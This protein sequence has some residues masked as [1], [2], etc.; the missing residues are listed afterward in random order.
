MTFVVRRL[1]FG[2]L[3]LLVLSFGSFCFFASQPESFPSGKPVL[4]E[5]WTW[6]E[7]MGTG[8]SL[9]ALTGPAPPLLNRPATT[10]L[11]ALGH[12]LAMLAV[13]FAIVVLLSVAIGL[14][15]A[16]TRGSALDLLLRALTYLAWATPAFLLALLV[17]KLVNAVGSPHGIGPFPIAGWPGW[18]P[19][20]VGL[21]AGIVSPCPVAGTGLHYASNVLRYVT[22]PALVLA[23]GFVGLHARYLR[24]SLLDA[25]DAPFITTARAKG[26]P[27]RGVI[28]RHAMRASLVTFVGALFADFG[29]VFGAALAVDWVFQLNGFG[30]VLIAEFPIDA[31]AG[32]D[33]YGVQIL[34]LL[35]GA[36][37]VVSS[38]V[39][40][41][42]VH[43][44]DPRTRADR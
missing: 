35:T 1:V 34:L 12:T 20:G 9:H 21:N 16:I 37:V 22:L 11:N 29:A 43:L 41:L 5:Y 31:A 26:L 28:V 27:E 42:G 18:C 40:E 36:L 44:L 7:G 14:A 10:M 6:L 3:V 38:F 13:A 25:L 8:R 19:A 2:F 33:I 32:I 24:S 39:G 4:T 23:V 17:Q 30:S 15:A